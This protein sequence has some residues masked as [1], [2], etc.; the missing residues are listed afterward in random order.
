[1][2][3]T[4]DNERLPGEKTMSWPEALVYCV[5]FIAAGYAAGKFWD[6]AR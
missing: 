5:G 6:A 1:M 4:D 3:A 2:D